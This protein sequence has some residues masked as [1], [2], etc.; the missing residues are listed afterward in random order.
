MEFTLVRPDAELRALMRDPAYALVAARIRERADYW[1]EHFTDSPELVSGWS[2]NYACPF[3][4]GALKF[5]A[6]SPHAH[7]CGACGKIAPDTQLL[8]EAWIMSRRGAI[9]ESLKCAAVLFRAG[10]GEKYRDYVIRVIDFYADHYMEFDEHGLYAGRGRV[11]GQSLTEATWGVTLLD[12]LLILG[13]DGGSEKGQIWH[14]QLFLP[15]ARMVMAQSGLIHNIPLW[16][17]AFSLGAGAVF[18]DERLV[19]QSLRGDLGARNQ[20]LKGFTDEGIWFENSSGYHY[21]A[22]N[23]ALTVCKFMRVA[24]REE[25]EVFAR[26]ASGFTGLLKLTYEDG[27]Q[28]AFN[29]TPKTAAAQGVRGRV[30]MFL[31]GAKVL[32]GVTDVSRVALAVK[33]LPTSGSLGDFLYGRPDM[34]AENPPAYGSV[35]LAANC[36]AMLRDGDYEVFAKYGNLH[37]SHAHPD[38]LQINLYPF[39]TDLG[40]VGYSS[41]YHRGW[42]TRTCAHATVTVDAQS[43][44]HTARGTAEMSADGKRLEMSVPGIAD[45]A[46]ANR[47]IELRDGKLYDETRVTCQGERLIDWFFHAAGDFACEGVFEDAEIAEKDDGYQY[48]TDVKKWVSGAFQAQWTYQGKSLTLRLTGI[49]E[50]A[51]VYTAVSPDSPADHIRHSIIVRAAGPEA[52]FAAEHRIG[53]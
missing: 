18:R 14:K 24:G 6:E 46:D 2:H 26:V 22:L 3:C 36:M 30:D 29:D 15:C 9:A 11:M 33:D 39:A 23:A 45:G 12:A 44:I 1:L 35:N 40:T 52:V 34:P 48:F 43:Q 10:E 42:Y 16:H 49:P 17:S 20:V 28:P 32:G 37:R 5:D 8:Y 27:Q 41:P 31:E 38:A 53:E 51:R 4:A 25:P 47:V 21:Y 7:L 13:F 19:E 50:G